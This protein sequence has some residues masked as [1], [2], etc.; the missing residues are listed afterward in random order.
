MSNRKYKQT[1]QQHKNKNPNGFLK[2]IRE[3]VA[4]ENKRNGHPTYYKYVFDNEDKNG[5]RTNNQN[6]YERKNEGKNKKKQKGYSKYAVVLNG[7]LLFA[8]WALLFGL[9]ALA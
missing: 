8:P 9:G 5:N 4:H 6:K 7:V 2:Y 1:R 3:M